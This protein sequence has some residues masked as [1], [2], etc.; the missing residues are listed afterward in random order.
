MDI[1]GG[2][3]GGFPKLPL[4]MSLYRRGRIWWIKLSTDAG[5]V[6]ESAGTA[7]KKEAW[8]YHEKRKGEI[9]R[10]ERLG[11]A[12]PV[13]WGEAV[14]AWLKIK[15]RSLPERY[16][17]RSLAVD[18]K[19]TLPLPPETVR[20]CLHGKTPGT[21]RRYWAILAAVH[22]CVGSAAP[23]LKLP[24][25]APSRTRWLTAEEWKRLRAALDA[26]SP[27]LRQAAELTLET[28]L[29]ENNVLGLEWPQIDL[30]R[31]VAWI[32]A[33]QIKTKAPLGVPL[34]DAACAILEARRGIHKTY[35]FP[36]P[37]TGV[38]LT[39]ASNRAWYA[40]RKKAK[41]PGFRW[42]DLRHTWASWH[43]MNGTPLN[44]LQRLGGWAT[45]Q[46]VQRYA[47][48]SS[49]HLAAAAARVKPVSLRYNSRKRTSRG[50]PGGTV[51]A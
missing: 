4:P 34:N 1:F 20:A 22:G 10:Q 33:D 18:A 43:V 17:L 29:R 38:P 32:Y 14:A 16:M 8:E 6:R 31:R 27:L 47:H 15:Q 12:P 48:L 41:L 45:F 49:E 40:A 37:D 13:T 2:R 28:G 25:S 26:E 30:K 46:M 24:S 19:Q 42:H 3:I 11:E 35:V 44:E 21:L 7:D 36:N 9:W 23:S 5:P 51:G 50:T 39:R